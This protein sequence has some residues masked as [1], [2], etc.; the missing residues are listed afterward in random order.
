MKQR[1]GAWLK[2]RRQERNLSQERLASLA[3]LDR[4]YLARIERGGVMPGEKIRARLL[5][6]LEIPPDD[7]GYLM[8]LPDA[9][10]RRKQLDVAREQLIERKE[11]AI[12][13]HLDGLKDRD[14]MLEETKRIDDEIKDIDKELADLPKPIDPERIIEIAEAAH[15]HRDHINALTPEQSSELLGILG[16]IQYGPDG[17]TIKYREPY[18]Y[19]FPKP[20][21]LNWPAKAKYPP[22]FARLDIP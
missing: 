5:A 11:R 18:C 22:P 15:N 3:E 21:V 20:A 7:Y 1:F 10:L 8:A 17:I 14:W 6:A 19:L 9:E 4:G 16:R 2:L 12:R 13:V